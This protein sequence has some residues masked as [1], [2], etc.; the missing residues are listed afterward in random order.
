MNK[1]FKYGLIVASLLT[2][3]QSQA[4]A[5]T[6]SAQGPDGRP[7]HETI[8]QGS[9]SSCYQ[10][11][12]ATCKGNY[13]VLDSYSKAGNLFTDAIPGP[14][15]WFHMSYACGASDGKIARFN[16]QG[17]TWHPPRPVYLDCGGNRWNTSCGGFY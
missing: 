2:L 8:C 17:G 16:H 7:I 9:S 12:R 1:Y 14:F 4:K 5:E 6:E 15:T 10:E 13:Q 3:N 11:A